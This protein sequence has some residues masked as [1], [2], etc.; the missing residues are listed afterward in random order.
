M[1]GFFEESIV[2]PSA[3]DTIAATY[4][5]AFSESA[6]GL[7]QRNVVW[8]EMDR[9]FHRGQRILEINCG[10]GIDAIHLARR[11]VHVEACDAASQMIALAQKRARATDLPVRF[12]CLPIESIGELAPATLYDGVLS[13]FSGLNCVED[14]NAV[15]RSLS[16]LV[17]PGGRIVLC[18]FGTFCLWE[19]LWYLSGRDL[20]RAFRRLRRRGIEAVLGPSATVTVHYR[21]VNALRKLFEPHFRLERRRG[22]GILVPPTYA[23]AVVSR[24]PRLFRFAV[25]ADRYIGRCPFIRS[26]ADHAILTFER[27]GDG[28]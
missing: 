3:F 20:R 11:G 7:A 21:T 10:T 8:S 6:I 15:A 22:A 27:V 23:S 25:Q 9:V 4:D 2:V 14:L 19:V 12:R 16:R 28:S 1:A 13:N 26:A 24:F 5:D 17:R 18:V